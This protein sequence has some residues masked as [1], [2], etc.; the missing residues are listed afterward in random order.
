MV[1]ATQQ[2]RVVDGCDASVEPAHEVVTV[3]PPGRTVTSR[4]AASP[5][6]DDQGPAQWAG[7]KPAAAAQVEDLAVT[8]EDGGQDLRVAADPPGRSRGQP[9]TGVE[10]GRAGL[11]L[12]SAEVDGDH[13]LRPV[14]AVVGQGGGAQCRRA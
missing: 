4:E 5:V 11:F 7:D 8:A 12:E 10:H 14:A 9:L 3:A 2:D 6:P 13:D 1:P